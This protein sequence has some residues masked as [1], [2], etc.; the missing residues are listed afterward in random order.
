PLLKKASEILKAL[1]LR[2]VTCDQIKELLPDTYFPPQMDLPHVE[3][4]NP[5]RKKSK[6]KSAG[7]ANA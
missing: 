5:S 2:I 4:K 3:A 1:S 7:K 6:P